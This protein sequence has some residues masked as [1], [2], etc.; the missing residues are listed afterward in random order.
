[1]KAPRKIYTWTSILL[2]VCCSLI[3]L[4]CEKEELGEAMENRKT[5]FMFLPWSTD[6][7]GYFYTNIADMEACVSRRGLE[8]ERILVF[9]STS[10]TE[11]TMF[12]IIHPKG[13][14][15]RKTLKRYGTSGFTTVE[16][17]TGILNDVQEFAPAP[18]Y[19]MII[20]SHGMGWL[21]V[22]GTQADSLFRMKKHWEYQ[23][24]P[25]TRYFGGLT[26]EFQT[27]VG[28]LARGIVGAGVKMEY[29]LF[30][31]CYMSSVEVAYELKEA[32]RFLIAS[33]SEMMAYGMPYATVGEFL[34]GNPDYGSLCEGFHDFYSTYEM[35]PCGTLAVTD[36]SELDNMAAIMKS[37]NDRYVFDDSLQGEL[38]GLDGYTPVIFYDFAD[39][40]LTLCSDPVLTARFREQ[41]ERLVPY[42]PHTSKFY[43]RAKGTFPYVLF[44]G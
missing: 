8:H 40:I 18:V 13:K 22:D 25:L 26:R 21:P 19:A 44:R 24:Q 15:D 31:D 34:L 5:L 14:C 36:C 35:M 42:K 9:M 17:I 20:G 6:L 38:Q 12:E 11:A 33:T 39:Y 43:S 23:E 32:T 3:F 10:S 16:G 37:I 28:T 2:F 7:T 30:D 1:M 27:D 4:S 29:I 41:L